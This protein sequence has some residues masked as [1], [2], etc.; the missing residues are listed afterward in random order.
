L[1][2]RNAFKH[3]WAE[4]N[5]VDITTNGKEI[6]SNKKIEIEIVKKIIDDKSDI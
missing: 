2:L 5:R 3:N 4:T 1:V 6:D